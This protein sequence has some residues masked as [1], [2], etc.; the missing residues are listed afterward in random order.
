[1]KEIFELQDALRNQLKAQACFE[2]DRDARFAL[3]TALWTVARTTLALQ[4]FESAV[5]PQLGLGIGRTRI[6]LT[7]DLP[8]L[9]RDTGEDC[10]VLYGFF[11]AVFVQQ[12]ALRTIWQLVTRSDLPA[13]PGSGWRRMRELRNMI[14]GHPVEKRD[15]AGLRR[16]TLGGVTRNGATLMIWVWDSRAVKLQRVY[17]PLGSTF[18]AYKQEVKEILSR[19]HS[20]SASPWAPLEHQT[21]PAGS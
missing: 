18:E 8:L 21:P 12:D 9:L 19:L 1:M 4:H 14:V 10:L 15:P 7:D 11:Q 5:L 16:T 13:E 3:W 6:R 2:D 17:V 20:K